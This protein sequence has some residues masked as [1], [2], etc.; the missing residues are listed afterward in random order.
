MKNRKGSKRRGLEYLACAADDGLGFFPGITCQIAGKGAP[1]VLW[2]VYRRR[3]QLPSKEAALTAADAE[4]AVGFGDPSLPSSPER[5]LG[6]LRQRG[7][8]DLTN[9][10]V[11]QSFDEDRRSVLGDEF[12][13]AFGEAAARHDPILHAVF[14]EMVNRQIAESDPPEA[15]ETFERLLAEGYSP[16]HVRRMIGALLAFEMT[17]SML[18]QTPFDEKTFIENLRRLPEIPLP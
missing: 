10:R 3:Q 13:P 2:I 9:Y 8:E 12:Q 1:R 14:M 7:F 11:A 15:R 4:I 18:Q 6:Y 16:E 5:F 17:R